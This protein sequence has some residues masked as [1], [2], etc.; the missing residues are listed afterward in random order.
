MTA[1]QWLRDHSGIDTIFAVNNHWLDPGRVNGKYYY[2]TAF[3]DRQ[4]FI[5]AYDPIRYGVTPGIISTVATALRTA[6]G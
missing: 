2:F 1:L 6:S 4:I 5:E 3:S